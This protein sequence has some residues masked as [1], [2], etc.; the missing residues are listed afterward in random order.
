MLMMVNGLT[1]PH[2][3]IN[4]LLSMDEDVDRQTY[5]IYINI[6]LK[7][8]EE[9]RLNLLSK[10]NKIV[11]ELNKYRDDLLVFKQ[12]KLD[13]VTFQIQNTELTKL[14][15]ALKEQLKEER[16]LTDSSFKNDVKEN[17]FILASLDYDHEMIP[18]SKDWV[19]R[20]NPDSKL[21]NFNTRRILVPESQAVN[22][23][24]KLTKVPTDPK[25]SK[26]SG[27][28]PLTP[29]PLLTNLQ[30]ASLRS[31]VMPLTYQDHSSRE[32]PGLGTMKHTKPETQE[33]SSKSA[34]R[35]VTIYDTKPVTSLVPT[36]VKNNEQESKIDELTKLVQML[37]D[38]KINSTQKIQ[39]SKHRHIME[40]IWYLDS[41]FSRS[42]TGFK[43]YL[44]KYIV[45]ASK[46]IMSFIK[47]VENQNDVK[48]IQIRTD[49][50]T[51]F[52]IFELKS[53][54]DKK[55]I[56]HNFYS[57]YTPEQNGV[58]ERKNRIPI[59]ATR[60][61]LNSLVLFKHFWTKAVRIAC[62]TQNRSIIFKRHDKTPY[63]IFRERIPDIS[64]FHV[65]GCHVFIHNHKDHLG[66]FDAKADDGY[67]LGYSFVSKA[68]RV[69][70]TRRQQIEETYHVSFDESMEAI[71]FTNTLDDQSRKYQANSDI[72]YYI[73]PHN[74][75]LTELTKD[76]NVPEVITLNKQNTPHTKDVEGNNIETSVS[77]TEL[78][79]PEVTQSQITNHASTSSYPAP[80]DR[81]GKDGS[82]QN[83]PCF[84]HLYELQVFQ[85]DVKSA[86][87]NGKLKEEVYVKQP[88]SFESSEFPDYV[89][90]LDKA[91]Y[92]L[93]QAPRACSSVKTP[94]VP[95]NNLGPNLTIQSKR[96]TSHYCEKNLQKGTSSL[97]L[98]YLKCPGFDL[99]GYSKSDHA[100]CNM[101]R[102]STSV[103]MSSV[104]AEYGAA[105]GCCANI[106]WMKSQL[107]EYDIH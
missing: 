78:S 39:E 36:K 64:Y 37:M 79:V 20:H 26:E 45:Q 53:F 104:E 101:D 58:A 56:Y 68:F 85:M 24:L 23:C 51:E 30:R 32:R 40:P 48:V 55:G 76:T 60:T 93:K 73:T 69:I 13:V 47:M 82:H 21:P 75:S 65:F 42:M 92:G 29:L 107:S 8:V 103:A 91:L 25:S 57:P 72:S 77:I 61:K 27:S 34:S 31:E 2:E 90:M 66:K 81:C 83:L 49:N 1:S 35:H 59:K 89:C 97:S 16:K 54:C 70:N 6:D 19:E 33:F 7:F 52:K 14:N 71:K 3:E 5:L 10:Y 98:W 44:H 28:K 18:K 15:H 100:G 86:F 88:P 95:P 11:F 87:L 41:G 62:Y 9:Q 63:E 38:E 43:G 46:M 12:A 96:I 105:G 106:L 99:K 102:K 67:F 50:Q 94:M 80:H 74:R 22:E 4:I 84:C 17:S